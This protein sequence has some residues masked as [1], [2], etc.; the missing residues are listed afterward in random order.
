M[1]GV[2]LYLP[3]TGSIPAFFPPLFF[4]PSLLGDECSLRSTTI[5]RCIYF[6]K[7]SIVL[8]WVLAFLK[9]CLLLGHKDEEE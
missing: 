4:A 2:Y 1:P 5:Y 8:N 7:K 3:V 9:L 6:L